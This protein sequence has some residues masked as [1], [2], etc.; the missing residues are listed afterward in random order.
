MYPNPDYLIEYSLSQCAVAS[1]VN[2]ARSCCVRMLCFCY[3]RPFQVGYRD[4]CVCMFVCTHFSGVTRPN[5][6]K[7][8]VQ[9]PMAVA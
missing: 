9:F 3:P 1:S 7:F 4:D 5:F 2:T 6:A 8:S